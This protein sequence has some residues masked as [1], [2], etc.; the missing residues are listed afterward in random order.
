MHPGCG[1]TT[2]WPYQN[3]ARQSR[4][5]GPT[6]HAQAL[7]NRRI[8]ATLVRQ[9]SRSLPCSAFLGGFLLPPFF[10][11]EFPL[12]FVGG[13]GLGGDSDVAITVSAVEEGD[14]VE[15]R[16]RSASAE[17]DSAEAKL[18]ALLVAGSACASTPG[19]CFFHLVRR[20]W[21][22]IFT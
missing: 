18:D 19:L 15:H 5:T 1:S 3:T 10:D 11:D 2:F 22:Q 17:G 21:N 9:K 6:L 7:S 4:I 12:S 8:N 14:P 16:D 13:A 20:F